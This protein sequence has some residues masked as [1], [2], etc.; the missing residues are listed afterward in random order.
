MVPGIKKVA[1]RVDRSNWYIF[2]DITWPVLIPN[3]DGLPSGAFKCAVTVTAI[4]GHADCAGTV[5]IGSET[6]TF[7]TSGQRL[8]TTN[9]LTAMPSMSTSGLDC[10][11]LIEALNAGGSPII[12]ETALAI[13][14]GFKKTQKAF[15]DSTGNFTQSSALAKTTDTN[16]NAG[17][18]IQVDDYDY[19]IEQVDIKNKPSGREYMRKLYLKGGT[20]SPA[21][22][23]VVVDAGDEA[24]LLEVMRK[25]Q[26]DINGDGVV[27]KAEGIRVL[28]AIP[29][30]LTDFEDGEM[31][32]VGTKLYVVDKPA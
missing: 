25:D 17:I 29:T 15:M 4:T 26:Y 21:D 30:D 13:K 31:F 18:I 23:T 24:T 22:R 10:E 8:T 2:E 11:I 20:P 32:K 3:G 7:T 1:Y 14:I 16:C 6:K 12:K 5:T 27:D 9:L 19:S 28:D